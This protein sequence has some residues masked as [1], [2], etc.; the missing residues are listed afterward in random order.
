VRPRSGYRLPPPPGDARAARV[1]GGWIEVRPLRR[2]DDARG[3]FLKVLLA[4]HLEGRPFGEVYLSV[5]AAGETRANHVHRRTTEWFCPVGGRGTLY[6]ADTDGTRRESI[7]F[8]AAAP[9]SVRVPPGVAHSLVADADSE[10]AVLAVAD[11]EYDPQD[12][13]TYP[14]A[15]EHIRGGTP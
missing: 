6:V 13:D 4:R 11:V 7:R 2:L 1:S 10:L 5:G 8:D 9:V 3:W 14:V 15:F 12:T